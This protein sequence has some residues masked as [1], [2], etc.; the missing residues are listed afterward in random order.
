VIARFNFN[1]LHYSP[2]VATLLVVALA[3]V[4]TNAWAAPEIQHQAPRAR[5]LPAPGMKVTLKIA[6]KDAD[7]RTQF[8]P[9]ASAVI[10]GRLT[11]LPLVRSYIDEHDLA[12]YDFEAFSPLAAMSY[13]FVLQKEKE[14]LDVSKRF[15]ITRQCIPPIDI[16]TVRTDD[17]TFVVSAQERLEEMLRESRGLERDLQNYETAITLLNGIEALLE[18]QQ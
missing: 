2:I 14:V 15:H 4:T 9:I 12:A 10:D 8:N 16:T 7:R 17:P 18:E 11:T 5:N 13:Q 6:I 3:L 1:R